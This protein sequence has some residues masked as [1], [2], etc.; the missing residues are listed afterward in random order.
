LELFEK[1]VESITINSSLYIVIL[2]D[3][4]RIDVL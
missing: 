1:N 2:K 3:F 4:F